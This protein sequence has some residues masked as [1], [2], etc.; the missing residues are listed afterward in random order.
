MIYLY[1]VY[2]THPSMSL[3]RIVMQFNL[4]CYKLLG[5]DVSLHF[6]LIMKNIKY[7]LVFI[8]FD[9]IYVI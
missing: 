5:S 8:E 4:I 3:E 7:H 1:P 6:K 9:Y 2:T